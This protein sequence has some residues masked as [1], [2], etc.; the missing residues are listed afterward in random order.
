MPFD[1]T[2]MLFAVSVLRE[3]RRSAEF[4]VTYFALVRLVGKASYHA[5]HVGRPA[6]EEVGEVS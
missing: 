1:S 2:A 3:A 4:L 5:V 6:K